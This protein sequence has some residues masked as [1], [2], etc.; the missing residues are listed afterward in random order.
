VIEN[1]SGHLES[2]EQSAAF[3][4]DFQN[5]DRFSL[6]YGGYYELLPAPFRIAP[7]VTLPAGG[8]RYHDT[9]LSFTRAQLHKISGTVSA[10]YGPFYNGHKTTLGASGGRVNLATRLS[11]EP[12]YSVNQVDLLQGSFT[13]HLAGTRA[14][15]TATPL[16][17]TSAF[18]QYN[19]STHAL[20]ANVRLRWEYRPGSE[21]FIVYN[22]DR[23]TMARRFPQLETRAFIVKVNRLVRF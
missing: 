6:D 5:A 14:T 10:E 20:S 4:I 21:L 22:E 9:R 1:G 19:S 17:F 3:G 23:D 13:T 7:G 16:M 15:W 2:R 18:L 11:V 12:T 8:Y